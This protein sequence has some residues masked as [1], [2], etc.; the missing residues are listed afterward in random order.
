MGN[1][2]QKQTSAQ[3]DK[4]GLFLGLSAVKSE[5]V[6]IS[7]QSASYQQNYNIGTNELPL[8]QVSNEF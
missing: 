7:Y 6:P 8:N 2:A 3:K 5:G 4:N 1:S